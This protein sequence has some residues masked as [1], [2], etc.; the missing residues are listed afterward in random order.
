MNL[1]ELREKRLRWVKATRE[2]DFEDGI[3][4]LLTDL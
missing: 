4:R 2:N 3:K 1:K